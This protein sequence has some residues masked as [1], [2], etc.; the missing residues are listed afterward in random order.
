MN[1]IFTKSI[2]AAILLGIPL[3]GNATS[4]DVPAS[5]DTSQTSF[6]SSCVGSWM[7]RIDDIKDKIDYKNFGEKYCECAAQQPLD[8]QEA[9]NKT[10]QLCMSQTLLQ[11][12]MDSLENEV[13]LEKATDS[14]VNEYCQDRF[15]L[16]F[17]QMGDKDKQAAESYC[18]CAKPKLAALLKTADDMTDKQYSDE[19]KNI[20][21]TCSA[22]VQDNKTPAD[23]NASTPKESDKASNQT[24]DSNEEEDGEEDSDSESEE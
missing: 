13:G 14:D 16:V 8:T 20:A 23:T 18:S 22:N 4:G 19:I 12:T 2:L 17:P 3:F 5:T 7:K 6:Q 15:S 24:K 21:A 11:D 10:M 1:F 9:I